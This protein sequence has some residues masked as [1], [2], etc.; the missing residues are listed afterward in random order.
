ML[1]GLA[2]VYEYLNATPEYYQKLQKFILDDINGK[3]DETEGSE[4]E[5]NEV[6]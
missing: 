5:S 3:T 4:N 1:Y 6:L 2:K